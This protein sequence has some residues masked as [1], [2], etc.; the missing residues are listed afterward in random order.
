[1]LP[2]IVEN[3]YRNGFIAE[4]IGKIR[5][6]VHAYTSAGTYL[7]FKAIIPGIL[8]NTYNKASNVDPRKNWPRFL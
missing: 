1:M 3:V 5:I 7:S 4:L 2:K 8:K 6:A